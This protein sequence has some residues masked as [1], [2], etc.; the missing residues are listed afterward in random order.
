MSL[1]EAINEIQTLLDQ[2]KSE[3]LI[4][5]GGR[6]AS[7][8][9]ARKSAQS[10]KNLAHALR[11]SITS[12]VLTIPTNTRTKKESVILVPKVDEVPKDLP[13]QIIQ[14]DKLEPVDESAETVPIVKKPRKKKVSK[15]LSDK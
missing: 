10:I 5:E 12:H 1:T 14:V 7:A 11:K 6:K 4:L 13:K 15:S 9:R 3:I 2:T 8:P